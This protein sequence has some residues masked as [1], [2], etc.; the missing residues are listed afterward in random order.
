ML[1]TDSSGN[2][3]GLLVPST[4]TDQE[5]SFIRNALPKEVKLQRVEEKLSALGNI[6]ACND[7]VAL[8]HPDIDQASHPNIFVL[9][10]MSSLLASGLVCRQELHGVPICRKRKRSSLTC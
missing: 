6:V 1:A 8:V 7:H 9:N 4:T 5:L 2:K 3:N 10:Y